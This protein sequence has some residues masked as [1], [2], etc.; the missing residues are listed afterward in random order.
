MTELE[1]FAHCA[2]PG[3]ANLTDTQGHPCTDCRTVF[4]ELLRLVPNAAPMTADAQARRDA[5]TRTAQQ[6]QRVIDGDAGRHRA[7]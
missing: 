6:V 4:G 5:A 1:L 3:C 7:R 2:L